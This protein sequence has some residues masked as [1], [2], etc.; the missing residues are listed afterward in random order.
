MA[1]EVISVETDHTHAINTG[2]TQLSFDQL[3][4]LLPGVARLMLE[5]SNR[6]SR[7]YH[8]AKA[9]NARLAKFQI[10]EGSK[11]LSMVATVQPR[12]VDAIDQ[13]FADFI[14]PL[15]DLLDAE[16]WD[17]LD[18][19]WALMTKEINRQHAEFAHGFLVWKVSD[20]PPADL[21]LTPLPEGS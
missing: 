18:E 7:G 8:A 15:R 14:N 10:S 16:D 19:Q 20:T 6:F 13:F 12:Y 3:G 4:V 1:D 17:H 2:R 9:H 21:D 5:V 11:I